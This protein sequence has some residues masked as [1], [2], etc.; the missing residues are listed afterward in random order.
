M[1]ALSVVFQRRGAQDR[2]PRGTQR[3]HRKGSRMLEQQ[4]GG[5][6][7]LL[8]WH[9][10]C[11]ADTIQSSLTSSGRTNSSSAR[12]VNSWIWMSSTGF[13]PNPTGRWVFRATWSLARLRTRYALV[14]TPRRAS[15]V[16]AC[17]FGSCDL[18]IRRGCIY[19]GIASR[20]G[21]GKWLMECIMQHPELQGLRRWSWSLAMPMGCTVSWDFRH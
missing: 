16:C 12:I 20:H 17:D 19:S 13:L 7:R 18:C 14:C 1:L 8:E 5:A 15:R 9:D 10:A 6:K 11:P 3:W 4:A 2:L 21:L